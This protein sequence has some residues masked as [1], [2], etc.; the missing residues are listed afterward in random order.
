MN[1]L[2]NHECKLFVKEH[3]GEQC[4]GF[5]FRR[6]YSHEFELSLDTPRNRSGKFYP[7]LLGIIRNEEKSVQSYSISLYQR[8]YLVSN[9][10]Y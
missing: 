8:S 1:S 4:N 6:W 5:R 10:T 3:E 2:M 9:K 7:V